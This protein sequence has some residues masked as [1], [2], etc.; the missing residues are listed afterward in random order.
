MKTIQLSMLSLL[1][2]LVLLGLST[3][4]AS[5]HSDTVRD[6]I[7]VENQK[8]S[9]ATN[10]AKDFV[11]STQQ[12]TDAYESGVE[13]LDKSRKELRKIESVHTFVFSSNQSIEL[14]KGV[15]A[16]AAGYLIGE[17]YLRE[18]SGLDQKVREQFA[19]DFAALR[20]AGQEI[21]TSWNSLKDSHDE[22][23][24]FS[25]R[26]GL[27]TVDAELVKALLVEFNADTEALDEIIKRSKQV[28][29][30]LEKALEFDLANDYGL[31]RAQIL[32]ED[33]L[34]LLEKIKE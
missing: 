24:K 6:L 21:E 1:L 22:V 17:L 25:Q 30:A 29:E 8:I 14:K 31:G 12:V 27:A 4:C 9:E 3:G 19:E 28:N 7:K 20:K 2:V 10:N 11:Q 23:V 18:Y 16:L 13:E 32:N 33:L 26:T 15:D 5:I 34:N